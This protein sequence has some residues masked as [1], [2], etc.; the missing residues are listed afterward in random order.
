VNGAG[1]TA[2]VFQTPGNTSNTAS[3]N[4]RIGANNALTPGS[5]VNGTLSQVL[6]YNRALTATEIL[7]VSKYLASRTGGAIVI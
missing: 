5:F 4:I 2:G 3:L 1:G 6:I 7:N